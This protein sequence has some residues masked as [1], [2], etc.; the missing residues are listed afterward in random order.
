MLKKNLIKIE[1]YTLKYVQA[2]RPEEA[3]ITVN[4]RKAIKR[5]RDKVLPKLVENQ[6]AITI[7]TYTSVLDYE[8]YYIAGNKDV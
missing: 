8:C 1:R 7:K 5:Y 4:E 3:G 6:G 2:R